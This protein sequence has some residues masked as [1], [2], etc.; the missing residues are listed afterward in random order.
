[1][2]S[3]IVDMDGTLALIDH[4]LKYVRDLPEGVKKDWN[5][6]FDYDE[7]MRD[8]LNVPVFDMVRGLYAIGYKVLIVSARPR[9]K[10]GKATIDWLSS[11]GIRHIADPD[12]GIMYYHGLYMRGDTFN[13]KDM[14]DD[15][16]VKTELLARIRADG[17]D[18]TIAI[19]DRQRVVDCFRKAGLLVAQV[20]P[21]NF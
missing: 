3:V 6:F 18:P 14:R 10:A 15:S 16:V 4:R 19:D 12:D 21:G 5:K 20:A 8:R 13:G 1:M 7:I 9:K 2:K 11:E 17:Y